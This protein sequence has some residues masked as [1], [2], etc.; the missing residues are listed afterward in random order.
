MKLLFDLRYLEMFSSHPTTAK[1]KR[2]KNQSHEGSICVIQLNKTWTPG[3]VIA[4]QG[5][6]K[7][8]SQS[9]RHTRTPMILENL[10]ENLLESRR[11]K[12]VKTQK[13]TKS[14]VAADRNREQ[15]NLLDR[16]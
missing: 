14:V 12:I 1:D 9:I 2:R 8:D 6:Q 16:K 10:Q 3:F 5:S 11:K 4:R 7:G 13:F 15:I